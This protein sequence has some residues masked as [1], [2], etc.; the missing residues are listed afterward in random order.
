MNKWT[1]LFVGVLI[2]VVVGGVIGA[3]VGLLRN[4]GLGSYGTLIAGATGGIV[5]GVVSKVL[6]P[7]PG[8]DS[9][10]G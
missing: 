7:K 1:R 8:R 10:T 9:S 2:G 6:R 4:Q 3:A 5:A